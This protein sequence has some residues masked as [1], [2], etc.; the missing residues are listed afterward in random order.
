MMKLSRIIYILFLLLTVA[1]S[2]GE[3][4]AGVNLIAHAGGV[5]EGVAMTNSREALISARDKG[6]KYIEFDLLFTSDSALVA[7]HT[8]EEYNAA[9]GMQERDACAPTL[10]EFLARPLPGGFTPLTARDINDFFLSHDSLFLVTDKVSDAQVLGRNFPLLKERMV[11]EAFSYNDYSELI[12][13]GYASV[14]YSCMARDIDVA[15]IKHLVF[16]WLFQGEKIECVALHTSAFEYG[17]LKI[18]RAVSDFKI[19][20]FTVNDPTEIPDECVNDITF[21]YTD[22]LLPCDAK[23]LTK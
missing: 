2:G 1:C 3:G 21:V 4:S 10:D 13:Q 15:P 7:C 19:A 23:R 8:W 5:V 22:S 17:Y 6:F 9:M 16:H 12:K 14:F 18:L 11:V 20:L